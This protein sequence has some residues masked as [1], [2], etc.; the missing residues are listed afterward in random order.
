MDKPCIEEYL[1]DVSFSP[2]P[3]WQNPLLHF[4]SKWEILG[5]AEKGWVKE[6][7]VVGIGE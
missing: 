7:N 2:P 6:G 1:S 3:F 5:V 4:T